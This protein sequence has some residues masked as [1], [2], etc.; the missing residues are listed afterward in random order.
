VID[1]LRLT[2]EEAGGLNERGDVSGA[3]LAGA[4]VEAIEARDPELHAYL[5]VAGEHG[6]GVPIAHKEVITT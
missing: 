6:E 1:T 5:Q 3:E 4:D 2:A